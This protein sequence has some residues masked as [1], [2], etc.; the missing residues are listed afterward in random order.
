[1]QIYCENNQEVVDSILMS[2]KIGEHEDILLPTIVNLD[3]FF[4]SH[5]SQVVDLYDENTID[6]FL[7]SYRPKIKLDVEDPRA[8][9]GLFLGLCF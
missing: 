1:M 3:A 2:Y 7:P 5:T 9:G 8:F 4:L 6:K